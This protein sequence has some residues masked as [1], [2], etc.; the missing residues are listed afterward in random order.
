MVLAFNLNR[1]T[2]EFRYNLRLAYPVI[3]GLVGHAIVQ[4]VDNIMVGHLGPTELAA[5]SL[6][7]SFVFIAMAIGIGFS[8]AITPLVAESFTANRPLVIKRV[9]SSGLIMCFSLGVIL[10]FL[11]FITHPVLHNMGQSPEV[12]ALTIPY[13]KWVSISL[14]PLISFQAFKQFTDGLS[15]TLPAM[16]ATIL[17]NVANVGLNFLLIFGIGFFPAMGVEGAGLGTMIARCFM[18]VF[19]IFYIFNHNEISRCLPRAREWAFKRVIFN[20]II[21]IGYP[22]ALQMFF[23]FLFFTSAIWLSGILGKLPQAANQIALNLTSVTFLFAVGIGVAG[24]IRVGNYKGMKN[25]TDLKRVAYS[26]FLLMLLI[27]IIFCL[28]FIVSR[29]QLP[30]MYMDADNFQ[31]IDDIRIVIL[32]ASQLLFI[33]AFFQ[34]FDGLQAVVLGALRGLQDVK[35]PAWICFFAYGFVGFPISYYYTVRTDFGIIGIWIGLM[36]GL[37]ISSLCLFIRFR[38]LSNRLIRLS[39]S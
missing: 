20:K 27:D 22:S 2:S 30:W 7:N 25:Y 6:G 24:T 3:L 9:L 39:I 33:S 28:F 32:M 10:C 29:H 21:S 8:T 36:A 15:R 16:Y 18:L 31:Q 23:E 37:T 4:L 13:L 1:Y 35:V 11:V 5:V 26:I 19:I 38:S 34:L 14:I 17:G 12:V